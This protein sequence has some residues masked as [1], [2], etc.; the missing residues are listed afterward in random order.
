MKKIYLVEDNRA[1]S[2]MI[3]I[4]LTE[5]GFTVCSSGTVA[6]FKRQMG[7]GIPDMFILDIMLPDGNGID[8][9]RELKNNPQTTAIPVLVMSAHTD[10]REK[11]LEA[12][13]DDFMNKPFDIS[14]FTRAV[15]RLTAAQ[16]HG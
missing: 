6:S 16:A 8:I 7:N 15:F 10:V 2:E 12:D 3:E 4:L 9:C 1:I 11:A 13:A 14:E 5:K